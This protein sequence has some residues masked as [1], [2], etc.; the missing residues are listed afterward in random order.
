MAAGSVA[1]EHVYEPIAACEF[2]D[3]SHRERSDR[4]DRCDPGEGLQPHDRSYPLTPTLSPWERGRISV[5]ARFGLTLQDKTKS[6]TSSNM[7][8]ALRFDPI[9]LPPECEK[10]RKE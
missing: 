8:A 3:L 2:I 7:T 1:V 10:L 4:I 5:A 6:G 9:R